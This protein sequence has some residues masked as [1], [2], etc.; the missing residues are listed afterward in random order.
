V[1][2]LYFSWIRQKTGVSEENFPLPSSVSTVE[3][4][5]DTL[6]KR[7]PGFAEAFHNSALVRCAVDHKH[8]PFNTVLKGNEE[9]AFFPPVTG[10]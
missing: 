9:V 2:L 8:V 6:R 1:K 10:G 5:I 7:G 3:E 4:L